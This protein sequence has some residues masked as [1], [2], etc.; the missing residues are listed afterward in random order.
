MVCKQ[1]ALPVVPTPSASAAPLIGLGTALL[2][3]DKGAVVVLDVEV[4]M[5][6]VG[7]LALETAILERGVVA[8]LDG[9]TSTIVTLS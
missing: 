3:P 1:K 5:I 8:A 7:A 2:I 4:S 6:A 9:E